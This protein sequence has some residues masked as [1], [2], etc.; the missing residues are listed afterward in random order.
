MSTQAVM[1]EGTQYSKPCLAYAYGGC[2]EGVC[3]KGY[4]H[5]DFCPHCANNECKDGDDCT[6]PKAVQVI[7]KNGK[8][9]EKTERFWV[10]EGETKDF[11]IV[12]ETKAMI[13]KKQ[14][15]W[16]K[17]EQEE[18]ARKAAEL[19][20]KT[21]HATGTIQNRITAIPALKRESAAH[22]KQ[23]DTWL[24]EM[25]KNPDRAELLVPM[26]TRK[27]KQLSIMID[28]MAALERK[29]VDD[30]RSGLE[31]LPTAIRANHQKVLDELPASKPAEDDA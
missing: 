25:S 23:I 1:F 11:F 20:A 13:A 21:V 15:A 9:T 30:L 19:K 10:I 22:Y 29:A 26:I 6:R 5:V 12:F 31:S 3:P 28:E 14:A 7:N 24:N 27:F 2:V 4:K 16:Q 17:A 8:V 18:Q